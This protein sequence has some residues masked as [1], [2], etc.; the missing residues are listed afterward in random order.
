MR[1]CLQRQA[2]LFGFHLHTAQAGAGGSLGAFLG[3][4]GAPGWENPPEQEHRQVSP[5]QG[6]PT[7]PSPCASHTA[8]APKAPP[9]CPSGRRAAKSRG[10][11]VTALS[12]GV[13]AWA[14]LV[15]TKTPEFPEKTQQKPRG[16]SEGQAS[17]TELCSGAPAGCSHTGESFSIHTGRTDSMQKYPTGHVC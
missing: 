8:A 14:V 13:P 17:G 16:D 11:T 4:P 6:D 15:G 3:S 10:V 1:G 12:G 5:H 7:A 9:A 2:Q